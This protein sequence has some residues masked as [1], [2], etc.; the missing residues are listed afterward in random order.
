VKSILV[1]NQVIVKQAGH[2]SGTE[3]G[4][5]QES[6]KMAKHEH[7]LLEVALVSPMVAAD[8]VMALVWH[9][10]TVPFTTGILHVATMER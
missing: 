9:Q 3:E 4:P 7:H 8:R 1:A 5:H 10:G 2:E 6:G